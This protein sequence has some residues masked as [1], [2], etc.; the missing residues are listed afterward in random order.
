MITQEQTLIEPLIQHASDLNLTVKSAST[1]AIARQIMTRNPPDVILLDLSS[2]EATADGMQFLAELTHQFP[3]APVLVLS[4]QNQLINRVK[5]AHL[6]C[7]TFLPKG[8]SVDC[9]LEAISEVLNQ[10][11]NADAKVLIT[12]DDLQILSVL[13]TLLKPWGLQVTTLS[14]PRQFWDVLEVATPDLLILDIEMPHFSGIDLCQVVRNDT[15]W[16]SLPI[17]FLSAHQDAATVRQVFNVGADDYIAKPI[18]EP[19]L[20]ARV[21]NRLERVRM[22]RKLSSVH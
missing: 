4:E 1:F 21:L 5:I 13:T 8:S 3:D 10:T 22:R 14:D 12:D 9:I 18:L 6:G 17:L 11:R 19:E 2:M 16:G 20:V 7:K 15:R